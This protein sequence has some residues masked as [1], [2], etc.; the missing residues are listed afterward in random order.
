MHGGMI[1]SSPMISYFVD[2]GKFSLSKKIACAY[3]LKVSLISPAKDCWTTYLACI[4]LYNT[5]SAFF[6]PWIFDSLHHR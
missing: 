4:R 2:H 1:S 5:G 6:L 3:E